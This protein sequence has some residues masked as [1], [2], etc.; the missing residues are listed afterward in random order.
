[1]LIALVTMG[2]NA[3]AMQQ[4][5]FSAITL[6]NVN[7]LQRIASW[8]PDNKL[9]SLIT[10]LKVA[11]KANVILIEN[12]FLNLLGTLDLE[13]MEFGPVVQFDMGNVISGSAISPK[14]QVIAA[15]SQYHLNL[16]D[17]TTGELLF[18][19]RAEEQ[20]RTINDAGFSTNGELLVY[21]EGNIN[22]PSLKDGIRL[23]DVNAKA[24]TAAYAF[25]SAAQVVF[26]CNGACFVATSGNGGM[27][28][29]DIQ[30]AKSIEIRGADG[31]ATLDLIKVTDD[32]IGVGFY[33]SLGDTIEYALEFWSISTGQQ[34]STSEI[35][36]PYLYVE[37]EIFA[38][39]NPQY[40]AFQFR[41][42]FDDV[43]LAYVENIARIAD[44]DLSSN[45][46]ITV[47]RHI[48]FRDLMTGDI[49]RT[50]TDSELHF[51]S[52]TSDNRY[53]VLWNQEGSIEVWA[54]QN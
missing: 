44:V 25:A 17:R 34:V 2:V 35:R 5:N 27:R 38:F 50:L 15:F 30:S 3:Q 36:Q 46:L 21:S 6:D 10:S 41:D 37:G 16:W 9:R 48:E 33:R 13:K 42:I 51:A 19:T 8:G 52:L 22:A 45:L 14:G 47:G 4:P 43:E 28:V 1:M 31:M 20:D 49:V 29:W 54:V 40:T 39:P 11:E 18:E 32:I 12:S 7:Q 26:A 53:A 23:Y 24:P